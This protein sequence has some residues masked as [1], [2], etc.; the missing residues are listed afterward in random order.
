M[1]GYDQCTNARTPVMVYLFEHLCYLISFG[2]FW[3]I[4]FD[5]VLTC[6]RTDTTSNGRC[7]RF[8]FRISRTKKAM[9]S[10]LWF[11]NILCPFPS[12]SIIV[13]YL[14]VRHVDHNTVPDHHRL[15][16]MVI[17]FIIPVIA[18]ETGYAILCV[19]L[20]ELT[21]SVIQCLVLIHVADR[22]GQARAPKA[23]HTSIRLQ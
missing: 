5:E 21:K 18:M 3:W 15:I 7:I 22:M 11:N 23:A 19:S 6:G 8:N 4:I 9:N 13:H 14:F 16:A 2:F 1:S 10:K 12:Q 17:A 20:T